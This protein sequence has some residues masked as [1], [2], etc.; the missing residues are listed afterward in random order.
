MPV[1]SVSLTQKNI[2]FLD[3]VK[4]SLGL[5]GRSE[6]FR[7]CLRSAEAD[8]RERADLQ[9]DVEGVLVIVHGSHSAPKLDQIRHM[10]QQEVATQLHSHLRNNK[11]LEIFIIRGKGN[12]IKGM[13]DMLHSSDHFDYIKFF[14]S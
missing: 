12:R 10:Y 6:A 8:L 7:A 1:I 5:A 9:G 14:R 11:C 2:E 13:L 3:E 4:E